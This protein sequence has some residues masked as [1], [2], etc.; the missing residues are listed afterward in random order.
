M[1]ESEFGS[2]EEGRAEVEQRR[3]NTGE[4]LRHLAESFHR[5]AERFEREGARQDERREL[6]TPNAFHLEDMLVALAEQFHDLKLNPIQEK[7]L[8]ATIDDLSLRTVDELKEIHSRNLNPQS[9]RNDADPFLRDHINASILQ[10]YGF[11]QGI[12]TGQ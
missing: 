3:S 6:E 9:D 12:K 8:D 11:L 4:H 2:K 7:L 10:I 1:R 5:H